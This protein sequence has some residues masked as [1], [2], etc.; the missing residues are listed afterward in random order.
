MGVVDATTKQFGAEHAVP[1]LRLFEQA[2]PAAQEARTRCRSVRRR[3]M[4]YGPRVGGAEL[5]SYDTRLILVRKTATDSKVRRF[6]ELV[7]PALTQ[8][9]THPS[10][11]HQV[12]GRAVWGYISVDCNIRTSCTAAPL[13]A[14]A[15]VSAV[16]PAVVACTDGQEN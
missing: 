5:N 6:D 2:E 9:P 12:A 1:T 3:T 11:R 10:H 13:G 16:M 4:L 15:R 14:P 7:A 8:V